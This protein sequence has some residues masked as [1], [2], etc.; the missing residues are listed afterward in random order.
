MWDLQIKVAQSKPWTFSFLLKLM[1]QWTFHMS[2]EASIDK[3][4]WVSSTL[5]GSQAT[6]ACSKPVTRIF[7]DYFNQLKRIRV[8]HHRQSGFSAIGVTDSDIASP[9]THSP[10]WVICSF[11]EGPHSRERLSDSFAYSSASWAGRENK[12]AALWLFPRRWY[13]Q[14]CNMFTQMVVNNG[15]HS[16]FFAL[17]VS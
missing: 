14:E 7:C 12:E 5:G 17:R 8:T 11:G 15:M 10:H 3:N 4:R 9:P 1:L 6:D 2:R 13:S 16:V